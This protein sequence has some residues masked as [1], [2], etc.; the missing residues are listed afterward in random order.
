[1]S[2]NYPVY[3][4][5]ISLGFGLLSFTIFNILTLRLTSRL[6][7]SKQTPRNVSVSD[8]IGNEQQTDMTYVLT[9]QQIEEF[10]QRGVLVIKNF[11]SADE[12]AQARRGVNPDCR[13][14][15]LFACNGLLS[16]P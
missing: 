15:H 11:L 16:S 6:S 2:E 12:V 8:G 4:D 5:F 14:K 7:S 9:A 3:G 13:L 10:H 1:M